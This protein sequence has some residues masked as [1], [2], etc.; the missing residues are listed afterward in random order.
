MQNLSGQ[1]RAEDGAGDETGDEEAIEKVLA[2]Y[3]ETWN[4]N[5]MDAWGT[6]FTEDVDYVNRGG[7]WWQS[8]EENV[9]GHRVIHRMLVRRQVKMDLQ[10]T[11]AKISFL[12]P[13]IALVHARTKGS[14]VA[15]SGEERELKG[16]MTIVMVKREGK[17]LIR[18]LQ[19]TLV[20]PLPVPLQPETSR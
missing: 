1:G 20:D 11:V 3:V 5:D 14:G 19:N 2:T 18:A 9:E 15:A 16:V 12:E 6:L 10:A 7:G 13:N 4:R 8:N 17:W